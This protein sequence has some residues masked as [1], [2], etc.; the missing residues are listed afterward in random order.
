[1][2]WWIRR[3]FNL[4]H[5]HMDLSKMTCLTHHENLLEKNSSKP[6]VALITTRHLSNFS[7]IFLLDI[8]L[9]FCWNHCS[10]DSC[11]SVSLYSCVS[12]LFY[13]FLSLLFVVKIEIH[14][15]II[16]SRRFFEGLPGLIFFGIYLS[17]NYLLTIS[18]F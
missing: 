5:F 7:I 4:V 10:C 14:V 11:L 17:R 3:L 18:K 15:N 12:S 8:H 1:M 9:I 2:K 6:F 13:I 16:L